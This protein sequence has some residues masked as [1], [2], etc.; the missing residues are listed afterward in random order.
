MQDYQT[1]TKG[2]APQMVN[3]LQAR[4]NAPKPT[5]P[6]FAG[7]QPFG[8]DYNGPLTARTGGMRVY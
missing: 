3:L 2:L 8:K 5:V 7:I 1:Q 6:N 4:L